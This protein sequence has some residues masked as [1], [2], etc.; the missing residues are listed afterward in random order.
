[1][2]MAPKSPYDGL[3]QEDWLPKTHPLVA[4]YP[5]SSDEMVEIVLDEWES[6]FDSRVGKHGLRIGE[7]IFP[8]PQIMGDYLHE[9]IP[10]EFKA[11]YPDDWRRD[12]GG[13][14]K[15]LVYVPDPDKWSTEIK[16]SSH[17]TQVF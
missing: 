8:K 1:M 3:A 2:R 10:Y 7:H 16:T 12:Q 11:G 9:L 14:D 4:S 17:P 5:V 15:D 6:I 13:D